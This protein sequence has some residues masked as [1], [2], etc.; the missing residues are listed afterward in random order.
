MKGLFFGMTVAASLALAA[1]SAKTEKASL[2]GAWVEPVPGMEAQV[3]GMCLSPDG[4]ASSINM[5]TLQYTSWEEKD[6]C[7]ILTGKS[8]GN[9]GTFDFTDTLKIEKLTADSLLLR[10]DSYIMRFHRADEFPA[11]PLQPAVKTVKGTVVLAHEVRSFTAEGDTTEYWIIDRSGKLEAQYD[12][13]AGGMK[14][15]KPVAAELEVIDKGKSDEGF[16]ADYAGVYEV[17]SIKSIGQ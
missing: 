1:C 3:Q 16:A 10:R 2:E 5:A 11:T 6:G 15:G 12:S 9:G 4:V 8:I 17:V 7:L 14:S 13:I